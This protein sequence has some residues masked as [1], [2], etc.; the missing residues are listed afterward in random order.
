MTRAYE[1]LFD[2][3]KRDIYDKHGMDGIEKGMGAGG[4]GDMGDIFSHIFGGGGGRGGPKPKK[5]V[6]PIAKRLDATL[7][8]IYMGKTFDVEVERQRLCEACGGIGGTDASA[9]VTCTACKG[10]GMR[11]IM[12][13]M[14]PGMYSQST[15]PCD[16]C[17]GQG[18]II[19]MKKRCKDCKGKKVKK[20][21]KTLEVEVGKGSPDGEQY[22]IHGEGD[23]VPDVEP[24]DVIA[25]VKIK[26]HKIFKRKGAD[27]MMDKQISLLEALTGADFA[28]THL[29]GKQYRIQTERG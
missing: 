1:I 21:T 14:G 10:R 11:T 20:N 12:R 24:G 9:V 28:L 7:N 2:K 8:D 17:G 6:K 27:L 25:V 23:C 19:D 18:E 22:T 13:Q 3:D 5:K 16:E 26:E 4:G 29:D 15:G